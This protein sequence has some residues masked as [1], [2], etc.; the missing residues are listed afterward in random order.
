V[1]WGPEESR[2]TD[3]V[4]SQL[5]QRSAR[6][7]QWLADDSPRA[8]SIPKSGATR[9][10]AAARSPFYPHPRICKSED[11]NE[12]V[13]PSPAQPFQSSGSLAVRAR[14]IEEVA[15]LRLPGRTMRANTSGRR[16][17]HRAHRSVDQA[18]VAA[19]KFTESAVRRHLNLRECQD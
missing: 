10:L 12:E 8:P 7:S 16:L 19:E 3:L 6:L 18:Y 2:R 13:R 4:F 11:R 15:H 14:L 9:S 17:A 1:P 5:R